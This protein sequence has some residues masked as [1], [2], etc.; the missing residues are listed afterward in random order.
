MSVRR[1]KVTPVF[2]PKSSHIET[3]KA[4]TVYLLHRECYEHALE[5]HEKLHG[6]KHPLIAAVL[7]NL[8]VTWKY[9]GNNTKAVSLYQEA[10]AI[11][12]DLH[13]PNHLEVSHWKIVHKWFMLPYC[14]SFLNQIQYL[15]FTTALTII[16]EMKECFGSCV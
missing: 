1:C 13:G 5:I 4:R 16:L 8:G 3:Y 9:A 10:L 7:A 2:E 6:H 11:Q 14:F 15:I 12:K